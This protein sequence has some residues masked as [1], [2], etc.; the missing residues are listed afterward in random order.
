MYLFIPDEN[1]ELSPDEL[2][3]LI[4]TNDGFNNLDDHS[5]DLNKQVLTTK[6]TYLWGI[7]ISRIVQEFPDINS[8]QIITA[9]RRSIRRERE[10]LK[11]YYE[12]L[13]LNP[14]GDSQNEI[15]SNIF[16]SFQNELN[17]NLSVEELVRSKKQAFYSLVESGKIKDP[18][19]TTVGGITIAAV[20]MIPY[21][22]TKKTE[23]GRT[24][25][26]KIEAMFWLYEMQIDD[27]GNSATR[28]KFRLWNVLKKFKNAIADST[29][30]ELGN[31]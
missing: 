5:S 31:N 18:I 27:E 21:G 25:Y 6:E 15:A 24:I 28:I 29:D 16:L 1:L 23:K 2:S 3:L 8:E 10:R 11:D 14:F 7:I 9:Y 20:G 12:N 19:F 30:E 4:L 22:F 13:P 26:K 17:I